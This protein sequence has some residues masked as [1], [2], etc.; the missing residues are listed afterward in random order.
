MQQQD[1]KPLEL[2]HSS[3]FVLRTP[4]LPIEEL[5]AWS[6]A[7]TANA[8]WKTAANSNTFTMAWT[9]DVSLLRRRLHEIIDRPE[10]LHALYVASPSLQTGITHWKRDPDSK[11][12]LQ[13]ER[14]LVRYFVRMA[15]RST[16]FGLF[17]GCS[18]GQVEELGAANVLLLSPRGEYRLCCR[19]DFDYLF[20]LAAA[21]QREPALEKELRYWP[22]SSLHKVGEAWHYT[23]S[24]LTD[25]RRS[26]HLVAIESDVY[27]EAVLVRA[28]EGATIDELT[29]AVLDAAGDVNPTADEAL[30]Y[31]LGLIRENELLVSSL[32]P[33][34]TGAPP[35]DDIIEQLRHLP[36]ANSIVKALCN[37]RER[38]EYLEEAGLRCIPEDYQRLTSTIQ[39][40]PAK[41][42]LAKL[43][44][45]DMIKPVGR[46]IIT[47]SVIDELVDGVTLLC[48]LGQ[49]AEPD[50]LK[51]FREAFSARYERALVPLTEALDE[52]AGIGFGIAASRSDPSPLLRGLALNQPGGRETPWRGK[53]LASHG[54]LMRQLFALGGTGK[55]ELE[56]DVSAFRQDETA[57]QEI[58]DSFC[59][60]GTL[61]ASSGA[62]LKEGKFEFYLQGAVGPS[63]A[64]LLGRF[65]HEDPAIELGVRTHLEQE[66]AH[67]PE[68]VYAEVVYLPEGRIGNVLCRPVLRGYEIPY[69]GRSGA[70]PDRQLPVSDLLVGIEGT[71][72][73]IYS[74][75]LGRRVIPRITNAHGFMNPQ[76]SSIYRFL[77]YMQHQHGASVPGF[78][79]GPLES[80]DYLPR[81]RAGRLVLSLARWKLSEKE[82]ESIGKGEGSE[83][84]SS[85]QE[86]RRLRKLPRWVVLQEGDN[87]LPVDLEN[88]L[89][90][91]AFVHV[92]KR[93]TQAILTEMYPPPDQLCVS[94][95]EGHFYHELHVPFVRKPR[96]QAEHGKA[97]TE[98]RTAADV[99]ASAATARESR[100]IPP[101]GNWLYIK[102][103]G[104][105]AALDGILTTAVSSLVRTATASRLV[106]RWFF[107]RYADP[108]D[109]LRIRFNGDPA[110][111]IRELLPQVFESLN[112]LLASGKL[113][114]IELDTYERE[115]ERYGGL[116]GLI[117]AEDIF[118]A[119]SEA[120]LDI[121]AELAG[122]EGLDI[123]WRIGLISID[124]LLTDCG[125]DDLTK[126]DTMQ[127]WR[128]N[129][130]SE[131][132]VSTAGKKQLSEK[133][134]A[135][136]QKLESL[137]SDPSDLSGEWQ[138]VKQSL[139][140]RAARVREPMVKLRALSAE[141]KLGTDL[142]DLAG[143][144]SHMHINRLIR[145]AQRAHELV[146]YDFLFQIYDGRIAKKARLASALQTASGH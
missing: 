10:I 17:S 20:A 114:K 128:D 106:S 71:D 133:F 56:L 81:V 26:H 109:H 7:L 42:D 121:L 87:S 52:E 18:V 92:L 98:P 22:N 93:G 79:W 2:S 108:L 101:G 27:L 51:S 120:V 48:R 50:E 88:A 39:T 122:D 14:A 135:E 3:F 144:F 8:A 4:L 63:G 37:I 97:S 137:F 78:S 30:E 35:L 118:F 49:T 65:C 100:I 70:Q 59:V 126:R 74:K 32:S 57:E 145:S 112:P 129:F 91:D 143:S 25:T 73:V 139:M 125:L 66:E 67:H 132:K 90:V 80:L 62:A 99:I 107:I 55:E 58:A 123:R 61:V 84:F 12:G 34:L 19:L 15:A 69:L 89:S 140:R 104:G 68:A 36:S 75:R 13:A 29:K 31:V 5:S 53:Q 105:S 134:R 40:L 115:I 46:A 138:F 45:V 95:A 110:T 146:L 82:V 111:I 47:K 83:R 86:L 127:R 142:L 28:G 1:R 113:F 43:Y 102:L 33:L 136:R 117:A 6:E 116:E 130:Q 96:K 85:V 23:E 41:V 72:I 119:D 76:L 103:Y 9:N 141:G 44:Q 60:M 124:C 11:K 16:P 24:R 131:F 94:S 38:I 64:R 77:C 21:L 54:E